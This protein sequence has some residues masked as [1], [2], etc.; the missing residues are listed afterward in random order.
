MPFYTTELSPEMLQL[1]W[2]SPAST[3]IYVLPPN[4]HAWLKQHGWIFNLDNQP[5]SCA[6]QLT[7]AHPQNG[8]TT[9]LLHS[10]RRLIRLA[11]RS[12]VAMMQSTGCFRQG[13][14]G[15]LALQ[16][17]HATAQISSNWLVPTFAWQWIPTAENYH[18]KSRLVKEDAKYVIPSSQ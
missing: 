4:F 10:R 6:L 18:I 15:R 1:S 11:K 8:L 16:T 14:D 5:L 2:S 3:P 7:G 9:S 13:K 12:Q 17:P